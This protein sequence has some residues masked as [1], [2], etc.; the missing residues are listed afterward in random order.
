MSALDA[1]SSVFVRLRTFVRCC[2]RTIAQGMGLL[3]L[4]TRLVSA[5]PKKLFFLRSHVIPPIVSGFDQLCTLEFDL[6]PSPFQ[7]WSVNEHGTRIKHPKSNPRTCPQHSW[8][9]ITHPKRMPVGESAGPYPR[10]LCQ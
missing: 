8:S 1:R 7:Q 5:T 10:A 3:L 6:N 9:R 2:N 4:F